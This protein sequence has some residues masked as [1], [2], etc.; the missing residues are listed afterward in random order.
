MDQRTTDVTT[1]G[2]PNTGASGSGGGAPRF[3]APGPGSW[4]LDTT[5]HGRRPVTAY[6]QPSYAAAMATGMPRLFEAYGLPLAEA[7]AAFVEGC[8]YVRM[9]GV[10]EPEGG[11]SPPPT[12]VLWA[13]SR[14]HPVLRRRKRAAAA[15][16]A[17]RR[18]RQEVDEWFDVDRADVVSANVALQRVDL[19]ALDDAALI[20]HLEACTAHFGQ[21]SVDGFVHHGGD[22][23][24]IGLYLAACSD[25]GIDAATAASLLRG[26]SPATLATERL[27]APAAAAIAAAPAPPTSVDEVRALGPDAARAVDEW[28]EQH[29]WR[30]LTSDDLDAPTLAERPDLQLRALLGARGD[31]PDGAAG[32]GPDPASVRQ[33]VP[34]GHRATFDERLAEAR[35]GLRLRDDHVGVRWNWPAGLVRRALLEVGRR[36][37]ERGGAHDPCHAVELAPDEVA[38]ALAGGGPGR[39]ALAARRAR[40]DA[41]EA[42]GPPSHLGDDATPPPVAAM[43]GPLA[44]MAGAV[45][46][47]I[48]AM[49]AAPERPDLAGT[50]VGGR[51][52]RGRA[53]V[54]RSAVEALDA[55]EP[56]DVLVVPLTSPSYDAL[57][58]LV[59]AVVTEEGGPLSHAAIMAREFEVPAVVGVA[60]ATGR[61]PHGASVEVDPV[62]GR[63]TVLP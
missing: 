51:A 22:L 47:S 60:G 62:A 59:G 6:L 26:A 17:G 11:G 43:P 38:D 21:T 61:V 3:E 19:G 32:G 34:A 52:Y 15:A 16:L 58:P 55:L 9:L 27:L 18:W 13:L 39:D 29:G 14:L 42:A 63:V 36:L 50:G 54:A 31:A 5:H 1:G 45:L 24:P 44:T 49:E 23:V 40:R 20:A 35:Y 10:G 7:R 25:W 2:G 56:D 12:P 4:M 28:L 48:S 33:Q 8:L 53:C 37:G 57:F 41:V 30:L 46:A